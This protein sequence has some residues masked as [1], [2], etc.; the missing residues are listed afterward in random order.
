MS[1]HHL[2]ID[3]AR[4]E[5]E[6]IRRAASCIRTGGAVVFPTR[7]LYGLA[8]DARSEAAIERMF[9]IKKRPPDKPV[10]VLISQLQQVKTLAT[11]IS[12]AA[13]RIIQRFWPGK[14]TVVF[15]AQP[16]V[17]A[18]LTAGSGKIG[19]RLAAHPVAAA[20]TRQVGFPIT[21]TSANLSGQP[22]CHRIEDLDAPVRKDADLIL[23]AGMLQ[24][25]MGSTV[26]D[27]SGDTIV[28][29]RQGVVPQKEILDIA[30][31]P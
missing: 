21:A 29:L 26:V 6:A 8:V 30:L 24:E 23:D 11:S 31:T 20:L 14:V 18:L 22:G 3:A 10:S 12:P 17:S 25:G 1:D 19:I 27:A 5:A 9:A 15:E 2:R 4:P 28:V 13:G 16:E 7:C